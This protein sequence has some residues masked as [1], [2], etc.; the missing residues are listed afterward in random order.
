MSWPNV[1]QCG[2]QK[3]LRIWK[4]KMNQFL[5]LFWPLCFKIYFVSQRP[6]LITRFK[7]WSSKK[8]RMLHCNFLSSCKCYCRKKSATYTVVPLTFT[9][10]FVCLC[11]SVCVHAFKLSKGYV[12]KCRHRS[13]DSHCYIPSWSEVRSRWKEDAFTETKIRRWKHT[14]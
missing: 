1:T 5:H 9:K 12:H 7:G 2:E 4:S 13:I 11:V 3:Q 6:Y 8:C 10:M 14:P